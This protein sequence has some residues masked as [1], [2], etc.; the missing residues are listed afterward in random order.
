MK[1]KVVRSVVS[2]VAVL[3]IV[4]IFAPSAFAECGPGFSSKHELIEYVQSNPSYAHGFRKELL[5]HSAYTGYQADETVLNYLRSP[6]QVVKDTPAGYILKSNTWCPA[7]A[8]KY[9]PYG[10]LLDNMGGKLMLWHCVKGGKCKPV[11]KG[12]CMNFVMGPGIGHPHKKHHRRHKHRKCGCNKKPKPKKPK[13]EPTCK[14]NS[15]AGGGGN[16]GTQ[17]V[18]VKPTQE[19]GAENHSTTGCSQTTTTT[20]VICGVVVEGNSAPVTVGGEQCPGSTEKKEENTCVN[21]SCNENHEETCVVASCNETP[22]PEEPCGC[23]PEEPEEP[24]EPKPS[25]EV[26][27]TPERIQEFELNETSKEAPICARVR[28]GAG[29]TV[30]GVFLE[31]EYGRVST[32]ASFKASGEKY[33]NETYTAPS[34]L[35][36]VRCTESGLDPS[37]EWCDEVTWTVEAKRGEKTIR[38]SAK[39][40]VPLIDEHSFE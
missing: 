2:V 4:A 22:P 25:P 7:G 39:K 12:Y 40:Q 20:T 31:A 26:E 8:G 11:L 16:C 24:E 33:C 35:H 38:K 15:Q 10:S 19:C 9:K 18:T 13:A 3:A 5:K 21:N 32:P 36:T 37:A 14:S 28:P 27:I 34:T 29:T 1:A 6:E 23:H 17:E 30:T